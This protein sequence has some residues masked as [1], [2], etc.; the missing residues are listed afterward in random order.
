MNN[1]DC[2]MGAILPGSI[3]GLWAPRRSDW[4][5]CVCSVWPRISQPV[6][7]FTAA[8]KDMTKDTIEKY[9]LVKS[10]HLFLKLLQ[11]IS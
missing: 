4:S 7:S 2:W 3:D 9:R 6:P 5:S 8:H 11:R 1:M 10:I